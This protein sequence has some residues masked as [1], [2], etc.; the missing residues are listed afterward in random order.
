MLARMLRHGR[1]V[2]SFLALGKR[3]ELLFQGQVLFAGFGR[4]AHAGETMVFGGHRAVFGGI[5]H[6]VLP[7]VPRSAGGAGGKGV[8][9]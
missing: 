3:P 2:Q 9:R 5:D 1:R 8:G 6:G 4:A 7:R